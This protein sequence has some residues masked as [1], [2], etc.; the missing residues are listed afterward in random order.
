MGSGRE[1]GGFG[2]ILARAI[3]SFLPAIRHVE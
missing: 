3:G 2:K 1:R